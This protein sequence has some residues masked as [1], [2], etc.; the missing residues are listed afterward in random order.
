M[1]RLLRRNQ[2]G[3][4]LVLANA[5]R[6]GLGEA[7]AKL[8]LDDVALIEQQRQA[9]DGGAAGNRGGEVKVPRGRLRLLCTGDGYRPRRH[10]PGLPCTEGA[11]F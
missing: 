7:E 9:S 3:A 2:A 8:Y 1:T 11:G 6:V 10:W 5:P 4:E